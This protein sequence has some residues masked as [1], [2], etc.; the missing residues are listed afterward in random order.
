MNKKKTEVLSL[1]EQT[2][3]HW[4]E[5]AVRTGWACYQRC[6]VVTSRTHDEDAFCAVVLSP[7]EQKMRMLSL[8]LCLTNRIQDKDVIPAA[9]F[10]PVEHKLISVSL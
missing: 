9:V 4:C 5:E 10:S 1:T 2:L 6:S 3:L 8:L 7:I